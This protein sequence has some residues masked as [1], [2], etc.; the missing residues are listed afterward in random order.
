MLLVAGL[1]QRQDDLDQVAAYQGTVVLFGQLHSLVE[2]GGED[3]Q[4]ANQGQKQEK[5]PR[6]ILGLAV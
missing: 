1:G 6:C 4:R 2:R 3:E 5:D